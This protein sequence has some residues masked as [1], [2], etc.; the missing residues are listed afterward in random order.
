MSSLLSLIDRLANIAAET[1]LLQDEIVGGGTS[2][3][4]ELIHDKF[5]RLGLDGAQTLRDF[6][7]AQKL[8]FR[9]I[10]LEELTDDENML[11]DARF[12]EVQSWQRFRG[13]YGD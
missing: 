2:V 8:T 9:R 4:V 12:E 5:D 6:H 7:D 3:S 11:D 13:S 10:A 1:Q